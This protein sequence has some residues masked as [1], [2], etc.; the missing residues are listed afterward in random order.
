MRHPLFHFTW[1]LLVQVGLGAAYF[2]SLGRA[3]EEHLACIARNPTAL[4]ETPFWI[5]PLSYATPI[6]VALMLLSFFIYLV[7]FFARL[8]NFA[9]EKARSSPCL[10]TAIGS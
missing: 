8:L 1:I 4:C 7:V 10:P 9:K 2:S 5:D 6:I 3:Y